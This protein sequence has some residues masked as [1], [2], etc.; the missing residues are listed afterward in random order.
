MNQEE[1]IGEAPLEKSYFGSQAGMSSVKI[2][3]GL[4]GQR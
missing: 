1:L 3:R 4:S 2:C